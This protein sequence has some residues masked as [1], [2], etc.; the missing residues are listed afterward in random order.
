M[1]Y[2]TIYITPAKSVPREI[3]ARDGVTE[4]LVCV[5]TAVEPGKTFTVGPN[6]RTRMLELR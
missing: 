6:R 5:L 1:E 4:G 3:A 2:S